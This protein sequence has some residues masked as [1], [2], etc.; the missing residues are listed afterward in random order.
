MIAGDMPD[1]HRWGSSGGV[2]AFTLGSTTCNV[3]SCW[4]GFHGSEP[5]HPV[6]AQ[7]L[8]RVNAGRFEMIGQSW[9][10]HFGGALQESFCGQCLPSTDFGH[11][12]GVFCSDT[13]D[14]VSNAGQGFMSPRN[15]VNPFTGQDPSPYPG[16]GQWGDAIYKRLQVKNVDLDP[17]RNRGA[18]YFA[19][20]QEIGADDAAAGR[21]MN[22]WSFRRVLVQQSGANFDL[23]F[24]GPTVVGRTAVSAW[25][26]IDPSVQVTQ[27]N[28]PGDGTIQVHAKVTWLGNGTWQYEY[29][30][31]NLNSNAAP[32]ALRIP[33]PAGAQVTGTGFHDVDYHSGDPQDSGN[34]GRA[35]NAT[36]VVWSANTLVVGDGVTVPNVIRWGTVYNFRFVS[37]IAPGTHALTLGFSMPPQLPFATTL[38]IPTLTPSEC[39][40]DGVCDNGESCSSCPADCSDQGG[41]TG[42]CGNGTCEVGEGGPSC[43]PD[44]GTTLASETHCA[45]GLDGDRDGLLDCAD[46]DCCSDVACKALDFD[47]DGAV[48]TCDC[49]DAD[50]GSWETPGEATNLNLVKSFYRG[51][52]LTWVAP[53]DPGSAA[54]SYDL[55]RSADPTDFT[56]GVCLV[57]ADPTLPTVSDAAI[58]SPGAVVFYLVRARDACPAGIGPL[59]SSSSGVPHSGPACH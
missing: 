26:E 18:L 51:A 36:T 32:L 41:G 35:I 46:T 19:E 11:H 55:I 6:L 48:G 38:S 25:S 27:G 30:V 50:V 28:R 17:A 53:A 9:I 23:A 59:G 58:P 2:T 29:A 52:D 5:D 24:D 42:C 40:N 56:A 3:G 37:N 54:P 22:N 20:I 33:F 47:L 57:N 39:D 1:I 15:A 34:W 45:D 13:Y 4:L 16:A 10:K 14:A 49:N 43:F 21:A 44:C 12:L 31:A 7:N 8:Y